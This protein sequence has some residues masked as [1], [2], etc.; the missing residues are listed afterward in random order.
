MGKG[1][2]TIGR[3]LDPPR[4]KEPLRQ[5]N[6]GSPLTEGEGG[7]QCG[8]ANNV[9]MPG[10]PKRGGCC[11]NTEVRKARHSLVAVVIPGNGKGKEK[12]TK[13]SGGHA[14]RKNLCQRGDHGDVVGQQER[15][16]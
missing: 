11:D 6:N 14:G 2:P 13:K 7:A 12:H 4:S 1:E 16:R 9:Q 15:L 5:V 8:A 10:L 3:Q